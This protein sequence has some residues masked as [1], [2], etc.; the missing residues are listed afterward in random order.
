M[1]QS[2]TLNWHEKVAENHKRKHTA[3]NEIHWFGG[4]NMKQ[5]RTL[6]AQELKLLLL[7]INTRKFATRDR[8]MVLMTYLAGMRIS[9]VSATK[10][11]NVLA[12]DGTIKQEIALKADQTKGKRGRV[13]VLSEK[14]RKELLAYL[15]DRFATKQL[16]AV[17]STDAMKKPLFSTQKRE[18][19]SAN[20]ACAHFG[21]LYKAAGLDGC[22]S[23]SGRRSFLTALSAKAVPVRVMMDLAGHRSA[24]TTLRYCDVTVD[25]KRAAV[26]LL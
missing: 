1:N 9:E 4:R 5:A 13:V 16:I 11:E 19:F 10:V 6:N 7:Y 26:E 18:G 14:L 24:Q 23:H 8:A 12:A 21:M 2:A 15:Q 3:L 22:S 17:T 25:M 20:T